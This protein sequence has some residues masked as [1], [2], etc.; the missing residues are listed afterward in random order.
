[1]IK[2]NIK[3]R[4][5]REQS[6][7][8]QEIC[9]KN[10]IEWQNG[11]ITIHNTDKPYL[12]IDECI[13]FMCEDEYEDF[14]EEENEEVSAEL[15]IRTNGS[16]I[17][18]AYTYKNNFKNYGFEGNFEGEI[19][20]EYEKHFI[21]MVYQ[22]EGIFGCS[23]D[24]KG[25]CLQAERFGY[26]D[27]NLKLIEKEGF[28]YPMWFKEKEDGY[29]VRFNGL[30]VGEVVYGFE[31]WNLDST[32]SNNW[33][34]H[35]DDSVWEQVENPNKDDRKPIQ[36][37]IGI[38]TFQRAKSNL[39]KDE[40]IACIKFNIDKYNWRKKGQDIEDFKKIIDYANFAI[41]VLKGDK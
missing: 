37:Q 23:W 22:N 24:K 40:L 39:T 8:V 21:G 33:T 6:A 10:G 19:L 15:F 32:K 7:K 38:D 34:A 27:M 26:A 12:F 30:T 9:F 31:N 35:T 4:V 20:K 28:T 29:V 1:M 11:N 13:S 17:E 36:Y 3:M 2:T 5:T 41:E 14:L 25:K 16:C 18:E